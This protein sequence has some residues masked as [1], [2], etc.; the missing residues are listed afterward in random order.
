MSGLLDVHLEQLRKSGLT[1]ET[2]AACKLESVRGGVDDE[3]R[4]ASLLAWKGP[5]PVKKGAQ[6][7][8]SGI[9]FPY[10]ALN[11]SPMT[12]RAKTGRVVPAWSFRPDVERE[13]EDEDGNKGSSKYVRTTPI[14]GDE[15]GTPPYIP[16]NGRERLLDAGR[17]HLVIVEGEKKAACLAQLGFPAIGIAG[18]NN[19][20]VKSL[21]DERGRWVLNP[22]IAE[23]ARGC[24]VIVAFDAD[25]HTNANVLTAAAV[26]AAMVLDNGARDALFATPPALVD[27]KGPKGFD[28]LFFERGA[29]AVD[30][31][32]RAAKPIEPAPIEKR[33]APW[34]DRVRRTE[35]GRVVGSVGN[36][37]TIVGEHERLAG[38]LGF[39]ER[40]VR[41]TW[42]RTPPWSGLA[43]EGLDVAD[44]HIVELAVW[45]NEHVDCA[46][47]TAPLFEAVDAVARRMPFDP[48]RVYLERLAWDGVARLDR[49]LFDFGGV[50]VDGDE[51]PA[52]LTRY[53]ET[54]G[55][56]W[57]ISAVARVFEP[58]CKVDHMLVLEGPQGVGK[59]KLLAALVPEALWFSDHIPDLHD[60]DAKLAVHGPWIVEWSELAQLRRA[61]VETVKA[62]I[63]TQRDDLRPPYG[64]ARVELP[65]RCVFAGSVN[66][67]GAGWLT[68]PT[69]ARRFWPVSVRCADAEGVARARDA[70]WAEAVHRYRAG[71]PWWPEVGDPIEARLAAEQAARFASDPWEERLESMLDITIAE[72]SITDVIDRLLGSGRATTAGRGEQ[73]RAAA[74]MKRLG[75]QRVQRRDRG[76][77]RWVY[78]RPDDGNQGDLDFTRGTA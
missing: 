74:A 12:I 16:P 69:G 46:I 63:T 78:V 7:L 37:T 33:R 28:D 1:D 58:G 27:G 55:A 8:G 3:R 47:G 57:M 2:I 42:L 25:A 71:E 43:R 52:E 64:R 44:A 30:A 11:G 38:R 18:V 35:D 77:R 32:M 5:P 20:H 73:M 36:A 29:D 51:N 65:R 17:T 23:L 6:P 62:F 13:M 34:S 4:V 41:A 19:A 75:W 22:V 31:A 66:P 45:M 10:F 48:V 72:I 59:S 24:L 50:V 54:V 15:S 9:L 40:R 53:V 60:K 39:N 56:R 14:K 67:D 76:E 70:L 26:L 21:S 61:D 49:W 68:D